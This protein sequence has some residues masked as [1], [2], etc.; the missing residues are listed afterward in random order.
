M[1]ILSLE[2][3]SVEYA[4]LTMALDGGSA[5]DSS[6]KG[7]SHHLLGSTLLC[8]A[9]DLGRVEFQNNLD[10]LGADCAIRTGR[11]HTVLEAEV[12][13]RNLDELLE[14]LTTVI[15][16]PRLEESE[17]EKQK[18]IALAELEQVRDS[19]EELVAFLHAQFVWNG[20]P[21][22]RSFRG[23]KDSISRAEVS[24]LRDAWEQIKSRGMIVVGG[25]GDVKEDTLRGW[26]RDDLA[27]PT[28]DPFRIS[29]PALDSTNW[30]GVEVLVVDRQDRN[31][32]QI[33]WGQPSCPALHDDL[34]ALRVANTSF[35]G[36]FTS[37]LM[38]EIREKR[39]WTYGAHSSLA[40]DRTTGL[41]SMGYHVENANMFPSIELGYELYRA[42]Q[43]N[44]LSDEEITKAKSYIINSFPFSLETAQK[45]LERELGSLML[46]RDKSY[47]DEFTQRIDAVTSDDIRRAL[48]THLSP[49]RIR[50]SVLGPAD[51][52]VPQ[53]DALP[54]TG[55][56]Q[57]MS[58]DEPL[59]E[60]L[61]LSR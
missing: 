15:K 48:K 21:Y 13:S 55:N 53:L 60:T 38:Q 52:L 39:G 27:L 45:R 35:G 20:H 29:T 51:Q 43:G 54:W 42:W 12:L 47:L 40:A 2:D 44:G 33:L 58:Y 26:A 41:F 17:F 32:A 18:R 3:E 36:T 57:V 37:T 46:G 1:N 8:G 50:L 23:D 11:R 16:T 22:G 14:L 59:R 25:A 7:G 31:Q 19:D 9:G 5:D 56:I 28:G 10:R 34:Y 6:G 61:S 4:F 49:E 24:D 30:T